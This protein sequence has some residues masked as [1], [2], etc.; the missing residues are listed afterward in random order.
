MTG[1]K[2]LPKG[3]FKCVLEYCDDPK[4]KLTKHY[5]NGVRYEGQFVDGKRTG[6]GVVHWANGDRYEGQFVDGKG[7]G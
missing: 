4:H 2:K 6:S 7:T 3:V 1:L 5:A